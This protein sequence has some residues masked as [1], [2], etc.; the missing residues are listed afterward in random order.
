MSAP[1]DSS[2][3]L[4]TCS[5]RP[6]VYRMFDGEAR[7]LYVGKA[8]NLK[9]RLSS[10]F[11]KTGQAPKTAAL[12][13]RIAQIETTI[14]ANETEALL[15]EQT[16]IKEWRPP[17]N[18][19]LRDDKSYPYVFL[20]DGDF[21]RL[22]IHRGAKKAKGRYFGPYPSALAIRESLSLLQKTFL[23][24]QCED[25]YYKNR[26]RPCL[27]YQ[28]KRCKGPCVGL[29]SPQE[30]AEDVRHSVMFL[31]GRSNALSEELSANMEKASMALEFE[32]AAELR[33]QIALLRRVQDQQSMEGGTGDVDV[34][35]V[36]LTP[37]GACVH[38]I[39]VRGG[40]VL[41][42]KNFFPQVAIEEEGGDV[43][44][45]FLA[46]YYLGNAERDLPSELIVNVQ[47]EDF[48]TLIEAIESL[49][50]RSLSISL[51]V[52]G[53]RARWQQLA[54]TNAEQAL[55]AR[56]ANRQHLAER[57]EA[58]ATVL[59]MD[60][61]PQRMECFD[62]SH[63]SGEA[64]VASCVVFGPEGPLKSDYRRFNIEGVTA[65][66]DYAAMHQALTRRFSKIKDGEGKL[67]DVLLV[68][69]G[70]GQLAM[71]RE[72]LQE[73]AVPD[74][75][76]LGVAKGTTRKPGLEVLYLNDAEHEFTL[77][78][79]S[80]ALHLIQQI[81]DESHR[82]AITGHRA[83]RGKTRRTSTLEEVAGIG[84]KRRRELLNHFGGLQ[85]LSR[86]S[87]E[88]IAKAPGISKKLAELI[89]DTLHSE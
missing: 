39:S 56:L 13:A 86:A 73:L 58:L 18:I 44:M 75:I 21:P 88:E 79:N 5:G 19:L 10:Y 77:P 78:G 30:Y 61:P 43:L 9:K 2:A 81:R 84:P 62:I 23:V 57:F 26:T 14:T 80:P 32:R 82:F 27:Q 46:Q 83:R 41:G 22:G 1:F 47:H 52:R 60:E 3:F 20:S 85:E 17:Y 54:V 38:L 66:D 53:T 50:G 31:D 36:M 42:S 64:T 15:L 29:V 48:A 8:K 12:V 51:R 37:G 16:L 45:A 67:P 25:S 63:S 49:R 71:A 6:G 33:D 76:L 55:A 70:K 65:G 24:R 89:Y 7:L 69:G 87:A 40:R 74:L 35:A 11:R 34:V 68:D 59:E 28:I 4:A 72:V